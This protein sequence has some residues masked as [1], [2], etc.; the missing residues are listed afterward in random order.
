MAP[1]ANALSHSPDQIAWQASETATSAD[2]HAV[3]TE[4]LGPLRVRMVKTIGVP[5]FGGHFCN[6]RRTA[7]DQVPKRFRI[8]YAAW[9]STTDPYEGQGFL[10]MLLGLLSIDIKGTGFVQREKIMLP[11]ASKSGFVIW[12]PS[13]DFEIKSLGVGRYKN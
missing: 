1:P 8:P 3:S 13:P 2:E 6:R 9:K 4:R 12:F 5:A 7:R 11:V 10:V